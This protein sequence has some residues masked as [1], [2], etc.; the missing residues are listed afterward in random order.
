MTPARKPTG[1]ADPEKAYL[2]QQVAE[3]RV[4]LHFLRR[5]AGECIGDHPKWAAAIDELL[6]RK[7]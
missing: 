1:Y 7:P 5:N 6:A 4:M 2:I 3:L